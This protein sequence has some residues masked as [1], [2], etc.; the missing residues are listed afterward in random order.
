[1]LFS[2]GNDFTFWHSGKSKKLNDVHKITTSNNRKL[3]RVEAYFYASR[4]EILPKTTLNQLV[5]LK[6]H[7]CKVVFD[8]G[9]EGVHYRYVLPKNG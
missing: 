3:S 9:N 7:L 8:C 2:S 4:P 1:M 5:T 6:S